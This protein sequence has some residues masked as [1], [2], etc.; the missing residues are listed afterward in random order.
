VTFDVG[1]LTLAVHREGG[2]PPIRVAVGGE[3]RE[4]RAGDQCTFELRAVSD[5][6]PD[7]AAV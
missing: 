1:R 2:S 5:N 4:L 7:R 3:V 6:G